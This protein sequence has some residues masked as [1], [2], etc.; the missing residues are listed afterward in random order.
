MTKL[1]TIYATSALLVGGIFLGNNAIADTAASSPTPNPIPAS[2][3]QCLSC[4]GEDGR[5]ALADVP[6]IAGQQP[7]YLANAL[8]HYKN[9]QRTGGQALVMQEMVKDLTD[10]DIEELA[11]W[12]GEQK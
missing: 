12:F 1:S 10:K 2:G 6:I 3:S 11:K 8:R 7:I 5:P 4:H 9:G